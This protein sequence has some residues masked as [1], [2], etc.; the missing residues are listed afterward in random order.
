MP[1]RAQSGTIAGGAAHHDH[2]VKVVRPSQIK[3]R[4]QTNK[5]APMA[6]DLSCGRVP[7]QLAGIAG[8]PESQRGSTF[9]PER[10]LRHHLTEGQT[11]RVAHSRRVGIPGRC[12]YNQII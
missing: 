1:A 9:L 10:E 6:F 12:C 5:V 3:S 4:V 8:S 7:M 2:P 11:G